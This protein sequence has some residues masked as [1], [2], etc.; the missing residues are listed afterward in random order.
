MTIQISRA[1]RINN[2]R[3]VFNNAFTT[4]NPSGIE[5]FGI[6]VD[7]FEDIRAAAFDVVMP[8]ILWNTCIPAAAID[9][10][11]NIGARSASYKVKDRR[12]VGSF[13]ASHGKDIPTVGAGMNKVTVPLESSA[14][15]AHVDRDDLN[16]IQFGHEGLNLLTE[17]GVIMRE[18]CER[19]IEKVFFFGFPELSYTGY[20]DHPE[21]AET[22][23]P[24]GAGGFPEWSTKTAEEIEEDIN[25]A[26]T[27]VWVDS[28][29]A[30]LPGRIEI[31][32]AQFALLST[33]KTGLDNNTSITILEYIKK[34]NIYTQMTGLELEV[35]PLRHLEEA[36]AGSTDRMRVTDLKADYHWLPMPEDFTMLEPFN[37]GFE[38]DLFASYKFGPYHI[39]QPL[40]SLYVDGI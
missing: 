3:T 18:A 29:Q 39:R 34:N 27:T 38:T 7:A 16:A 8:E 32:P 23:V 19:H 4:G 11:I 30:F 9:R 21:I 24:N 37:R 26:I 10:A 1:V 17:Y 15:S 28:K 14:I 33:K 5:G 12:G 13:R 6:V 31:P 35:K 36:G 2:N 22:A 25:S 40:S 20:I